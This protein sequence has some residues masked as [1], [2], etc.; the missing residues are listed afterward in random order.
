MPKTLARRLFRIFAPVLAISIFALAG[1]AAAGW[2]PG[3]F[4]SSGKPVTEYHC[5]PA[6][7]SKGPHPAVILLHGAGPAPDQNSEFSRMCAELAGDGYY[8]ESIEYYSQTGAVGVQDLADIQKYY[9]TWM[10]EIRSGIDMIDK[11]PEVDTKHVAIIGFSLGS[12]LALSTGAT[13]P[14]KLAAIVEYYGG[15]PPP[16]QSMAANLPPTLIL[17]GDRDMLVPVANAYTLDKLMTEAKRPHEMHIYPDANH[18]FNFPGIAWYEA[19]DAQ[20]AWRRTLAFLAEHLGG[21]R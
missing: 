10:T 18:A 8:V 7:T 17:H 2:E 3:D 16:M 6:S 14:G 15:L 4:D 12:Y 21:K 5:A 13:D 1:R 19:A 9:L 11:N 20:D